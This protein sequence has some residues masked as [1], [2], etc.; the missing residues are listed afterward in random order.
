MPSREL[1]D[2][3]PDGDSDVSPSREMPDP[4][5]NGDSAVSHSQDPG[6]QTQC[7]MEIVLSTP[8]GS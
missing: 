4:L 6:S 7:L 8:A 3:L 5:P 2:P 1:T